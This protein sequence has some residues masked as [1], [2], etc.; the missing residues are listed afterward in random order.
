V[1]EV[2]VGR[3]MQA[4][5]ERQDLVADQPPLRVGIRRVEA[6]VE[7]GRAAV[8]LRLRAPERQ[9]RV[10]KSVGAPRCDACGRAAR[11]EPVED[12][13]DLIRGGVTGGSKLVTTSYLPPLVSELGLREA[14][15]VALDHLGS[16]HLGAEAR[17]LCGVGASQPVVHVQRRDAVAERAEQVPQARRV[18]TARDEARHFSARWDQLVLA[19]EAL[20]TVA[21]LLHASIVPPRTRGCDT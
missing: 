12:R 21:Q 7:P 10:D 19:D 14:S 2:L 11:D 4:A 20:D 6:E 13:L 8:R 1:Q 15:T 16:Q 3:R 9:Q 18:G 5:Q 17:V